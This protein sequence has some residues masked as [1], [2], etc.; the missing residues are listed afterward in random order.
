MFSRRFR[1]EQYRLEDMAGGTTGLIEALE[2]G[3]VRLVGA[4]MGPW[5]PRSSPPAAPSWSLGYLADLEPRLPVTGQPAL[6]LLRYLLRQAL[7]EGDAYIELLRS[8]CSG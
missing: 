6:G 5:S 3:P 7:H 1:P 4:S 2:V 8:P